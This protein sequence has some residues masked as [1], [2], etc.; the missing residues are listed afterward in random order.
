MGSTKNPATFGS[1]KAS[2]RAAVSSYGIF[3]NPGV[4]GPKFVV[5][6]GSLEK[7]TIVVVRP[8]KFPSQTII[9]A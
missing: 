6:S 9:I 3:I 8:W 5:A 2:L 7:E 1:F 4:Y